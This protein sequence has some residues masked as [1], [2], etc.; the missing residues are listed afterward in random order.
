MEPAVNILFLILNYHIPIYGTAFYHMGKVIIVTFNLLS[1][2]KIML[3]INR[4]SL[5]IS[6]LHSGAQ[7]LYKGLLIIDAVMKGHRNLK[8]ISRVLELSKSTTHRLLSVLVHEKFLRQIANEYSLGS[9]LIE[10]GMRS[11][12]EYPLR[13][14]AAP[15]L[16]DLSALTHDTVHLGIRENMEVFYI[17]KVSGNRA[18]EMNSRIGLKMPIDI[19]GVG[20]A[21]LLDADDRELT[22]VY[23]HFNRPPEALQAFLDKMHFYRSQGY[24]FDFSEN[25][26]NIRCV[27]APIRDAS[28]KIISAIS[29]ASITQY[30]TDERMQELTSVVKNTAIK[31]SL[32]LGWFEKQS[33]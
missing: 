21:L 29:V 2:C 16:H 17:D 33:A 20:K 4:P 31:I 8:D 3:S 1:L 25:E 7:T 30:M 19:T 15:F 10:Y 26:E 11:L 24:S 28:N 27:A 9:K 23:S 12:E 14:A 18:V 6:M 32:E 5:E 22:D 13:M